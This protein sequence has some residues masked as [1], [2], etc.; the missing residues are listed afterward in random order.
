MIKVHFEELSRG[1]SFT[2]LMAGVPISGQVIAMPDGVHYLIDGEAVW[3]VEE[4]KTPGSPFPDVKSKKDLVAYPRC[5][6][7]RT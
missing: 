3:V 5:K 2:I 4:E 1:L 6:V 7:V